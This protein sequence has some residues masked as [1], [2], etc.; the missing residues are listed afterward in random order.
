MPAGPASSTGTGSPSLL[1]LAGAISKK[2]TAAAPSTR[3]ISSPS[4][5]GKLA[6]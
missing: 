4:A 1:A 6:G 3:V 5:V 2:A